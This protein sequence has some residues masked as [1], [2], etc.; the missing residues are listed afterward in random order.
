MVWYHYLNAIINITLHSL[1]N[2][3]TCFFLGTPLGQPRFR[4]IGSAPSSVGPLTSGVKSSRLSFNEDRLEEN[5]LVA[6][7]M[8]CMLQL[9]WLLLMGLFLRWCWCS[10]WSIFDLLV[11]NKFLLLPVGTIPL[12]SAVC[13]KLFRVPR[14]LAGDKQCPVSL[15]PSAGI[16]KR[17]LDRRT[18][19]LL[20]NGG[21]PTIPQSQCEKSEQN[22]T[23]Y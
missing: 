15:L 21:T 22:R 23:W 7:V 2:W 8:S 11:D 19:V 3:I 5:E 10:V 6:S 18:G 4:R 20:L 17:G 12:S 9:I 13:L 14:D 1:R 16:A